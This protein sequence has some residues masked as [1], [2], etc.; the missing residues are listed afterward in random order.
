MERENQKTT[1]E[2]VCN[3]PKYLEEPGL[4]ACRAQIP[5]WAFEDGQCIPFFYNGCGG[6]ENQFEL[7]EDCLKN[8]GSKL[9]DG[10]SSLKSNSMDPSQLILN[11]T[12]NT[13]HL[14]S[15]G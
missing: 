11:L 9:N 1:N 2:E 15:I 6:T 5:K 13:I 12:R 14:R 7:E 8:C 3:L 10:K 4:G